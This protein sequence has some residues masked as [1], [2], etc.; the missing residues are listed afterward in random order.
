[1]SDS[2]QEVEDSIDRDAAAAAEAEGIAKSEALHLKR[3]T[4]A[5]KANETR[6]LRKLALAA[7]AQLPP[8]D[9]L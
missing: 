5:L 7:T 4:A 2:R 8:F 6:R 1:M 9:I 3:H